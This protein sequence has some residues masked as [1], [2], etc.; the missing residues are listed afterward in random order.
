[1]AKNNTIKRIIPHKQQ[2]K[3]R[4]K[5]ILVTKTAQKRIQKKEKI[6]QK[7]IDLYVK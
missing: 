7:S 2:N 5:T 1:M 3:S 4:C 6:I